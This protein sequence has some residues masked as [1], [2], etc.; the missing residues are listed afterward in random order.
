MGRKVNTGDKAGQKSAEGAEGDEG[1][2]EGEESGSDEGEEDEDEE[3]E[4]EVMMETEDGRWSGEKSLVT[5]QEHVAR[6]VGGSEEGPD[7]HDAGHLL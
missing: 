3:E 2:E 6:R 1:A 4:D 7:R 5:F